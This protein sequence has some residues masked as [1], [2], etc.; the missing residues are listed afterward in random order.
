MRISTNK[1]CLPCQ[2]MLKKLNWLLKNSILTALF[3]MLPLNSIW[4]SSSMAVLPEFHAKTSHKRMFFLFAQ[5]N[6]IIS[7]FTSALIFSENQVK[8]HT[9][10]QKKLKMLTLKTSQKNYFHNHS[11]LNNLKSLIKWSRVKSELMDKTVAS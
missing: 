7:S 4:K 5:L 10:F 6:P 8:M 1:S 3:N 11:N 2:G 9:L